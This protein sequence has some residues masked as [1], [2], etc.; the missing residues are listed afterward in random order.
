MSARKL[1]GAIMPY[2]SPAGSSPERRRGTRVCPPICLAKSALR[3]IAGMV[4][5]Q[6]RAA[7]S[8]GQTWARVWRHPMPHR[9][10]AIRR[11]GAT[12]ANRNQPGSQPDPQPVQALAR[13]WSRQPPRRAAKAHQPAGKMVHPV[14]RLLRSTLTKRSIARLNPARHRG[15]STPIVDGYLHDVVFRLA[16]GKEC[17]RQTRSS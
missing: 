6:S 16:N 7:T 5:S 12:R 15:R 9:T 1:P 13:V 10:S 17:G 2:R 8:R 4:E 11:R 3:P 14:P